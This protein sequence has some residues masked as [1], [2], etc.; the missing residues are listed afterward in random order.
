MHQPF[1]SIHRISFQILKINPTK[2]IILDSLVLMGGNWIKNKYVHNTFILKN[3][4]GRHSINCLKF[5]F[6]NVSQ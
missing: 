4:F 6:S 3:C 2:L 1:S 5:F